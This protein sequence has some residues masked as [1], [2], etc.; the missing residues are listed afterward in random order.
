MLSVHFMTDSGF[1][2]IGGPI[3]LITLLTIAALDAIGMAIL[4]Y[5]AQS[6][7]LREQSK[8]GSE[9][10]KTEPTLNP[11][12]ATCHA[13]FFPLAFLRQRTIFSP[14]ESGIALIECQKHAKLEV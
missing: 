11:Q 10:S 2:D 9:L 8:R 14:I 13:F 1:R 4:V 12:S 5:T 6:L 3:D 7:I